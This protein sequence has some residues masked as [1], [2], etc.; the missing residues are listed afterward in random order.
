MILVLSVVAIGAAFFVYK[1]AYPAHLRKRLL[2]TTQDLIEKHSDQLVRKR[3]QLVWRDAYGKWQLDKWEKEVEYFITTHIAPSLTD[4]E[5]SILV[6]ERSQFHNLICDHI[7]TALGDRPVFP[8]FSDNMTP[9]EFEMF[10]ADQLQQSGWDARVTRRSRDQGVDVVAEKAG[11]RLVLQCKL[12]SGPVGNKA[13]QEIAAGKVHEQAH[14]G[15]VVT[16]S[17]YTSSA[18]QL[19]AT[20]G[21]LLLHYRD[22]A[23]LENLLR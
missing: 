2:I 15:A 3:A 11:V 18:E 1:I 22:L 23:S 6:R 20:N 12:Y 10:C 17:R 13:V 9:S 21:V 5:R 7:E 8:E 14:F 19:A 16:N 4:A